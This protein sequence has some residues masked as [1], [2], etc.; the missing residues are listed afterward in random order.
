[1][2]VEATHAEDE[3][4]ATIGRV[5]TRVK[6]MRVVEEPFGTRQ[7]ILRA[8]DPVQ[9]T[10]ERP[11]ARL[12]RAEAASD[13]MRVAL[14]TRGGQLMDRVTEDAP[15]ALRHFI[16]MKRRTAVDP[17]QIDHV[18]EWVA[19]SASWL[20]AHPDQL[21]EAV[22]E[23]DRQA[24]EARA[25]LM[26]APSHGVSTFFGVVARLDT[27]HGEVDGGGQT[28]LVSRDLP[29]REGLATIDSRSPSSRRSCPEASTAASRPPWRP[30]SRRA[31]A[32]RHTTR[33]SPRKASSPRAWTRAIVRGFGER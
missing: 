2:F 3:A 27:L 17:A 28:P 16:A 32:H 25:D 26:P 24:V 4:E 18:G 10:T 13:G 5:R 12:R 1:L 30:S 14:R 23:L 15:P 6:R 22:V 19:R 21:L 20:T 9:L 11:L 29:E 7:S 31:F 33:I 8:L